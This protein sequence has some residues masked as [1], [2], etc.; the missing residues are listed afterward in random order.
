MKLAASCTLPRRSFNFSRDPSGGGASRG[1]RET[2]GVVISRNRIEF[3]DTRGR[4]ATLIASI[5][6]H[7]RLMNGTN[8]LAFV[9][10][11]LSLDL[12]TAGGR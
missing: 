8:V 2:S 10:A 4:H 6:R 1:R 12:S 5:S 7:A 11:G 9:R 3:P